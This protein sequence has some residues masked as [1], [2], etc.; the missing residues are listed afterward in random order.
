MLTAPWHLLSAELSSCLCLADLLH[1]CLTTV[2]TRKGMGMGIEM[3]MDMGMEE[4]GGGRGVVSKGNRDV[5]WLHLLLQILNLHLC[6]YT[7]RHTHI[8]VTLTRR[9]PVSAFGILATGVCPPTQPI[10][11]GYTY[12]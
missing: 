12:D 5:V 11:W 7:Q 6:H 8:S 1:V 3:D 4:E 10:I 2:G 9:I